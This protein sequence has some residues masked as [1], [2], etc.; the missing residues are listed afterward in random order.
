MLKASVMQMLS[1]RIPELPTGITEDMTCRLT[2]AEYQ[3]VLKFHSRKNC[4]KEI[5]IVRK[6]P[7]AAMIATGF[8]LFVLLG[9]IT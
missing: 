1:S 3:A 6:I 7:F 9:W 4:P 5:T 8:A 2:E